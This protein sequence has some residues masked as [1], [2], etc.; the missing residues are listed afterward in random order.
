MTQR[1]QYN[2]PLSH[3]EAKLS[4]AV[5]EYEHFMCEMPGTTLVTQ[6]AAMQRCLELAQIVIDRLVPLTSFPEHVARDYK[7]SLQSCQAKRDYMQKIYNDRFSGT[8]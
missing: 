2:K 3:Y 6:Q 4:T 7:E 5:E 8:C 1:S